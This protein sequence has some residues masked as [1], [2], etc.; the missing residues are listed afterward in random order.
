MSTPTFVILIVCFAAL[1]LG[2]DLKTIN[3]IEYKRVKV[4]RVEPDGIVII[5]KTGVT[6]LLFSELP[7][8]VQQQ[9]GHGPAKIEAKSPA[10][11]T[12]EEKEERVAQQKKPQE[13]KPTLLIKA[14][15]LI[16]GVIAPMT[17]GVW[18]VLVIAVGLFLYFIP[19]MVGLRKADAVAIF[20]F[21]F[22]LGWTFLG[23]VLALVWACTKDRVI[24]PLGGDRNVE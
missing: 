23:W 22:F 2:D 9:F 8:E 7:T 14:T 10:A 11:R 16:T 6:K 4:S 18:I 21:N 15:A 12:G 17:H 20:V 13:T 24:N 19:S 1:A 3:G 5:H